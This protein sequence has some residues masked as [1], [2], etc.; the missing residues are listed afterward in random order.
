[1]ANVFVVKTQFKGADRLSPV[2]KRIGINVER[3]GRTATKSFKRATKAASVFGG[4][5]K[6]NLV[7]GAIQRG[8]MAANNAIRGLTEEFV[9][10]DK[11]ITKAIVRLPGGLDRSSDAFQKFG[12]I[13]RR[14]AKRTEFT[15]GE[16]AAAVEQL[17]LAGFDLDTVS[18]TL[19]GV[20]N[21]ATN[22]EADLASATTM[23]VKT[24]GAFSLKG[25]NAADKA[26]ELTRVNNVF[27]KSISS[28]A[29]DMENLFEVIKFGGPAADSAGVKL[30]EFVAVAQI[31]ADASIDS[32]VA[33][34][35]MRTMFTSLA[36]LSPKAT[37]EL[38]KMGVKVKDNRIEFDK[39]EDVIGKIEKATS[40]MG[41]Q[42]RLGALKTIFGK[43]AVNAATKIIAK[44]A[45]GVKRYTKELSGLTDESE[46]MAK[47][48]RTSIEGRLKRLKSALVEVG[49]KF[50]EAFNQNA[51]DSIE[52]LIKTVSKFD[53]KPVVKALKDIISFSKELF[54]TLKPFL[55][56]MPT[57]I[58]MWVAYKAA[59][60]AVTVVQAA[61][62]FVQVATAM[63]TAAAAQGALNLVMA[64]NPIA[65]VTIAIVGLTAALA[66]LIT[67]NDDVVVS[68]ESMFSDIESFASSSIAFILGKLADLT[69]ALA[70]VGKFLGFEGT[71]NIEFASGLRSMQKN[72]EMASKDA[73]RRSREALE[74]RAG[75]GVQRGI[76]GIRGATAGPGVKAPVS[77]FQIAK[78]AKLRSINPL[79]GGFASRLEQRPRAPQ[80]PNRTEVEAKRQTIQATMEFKGDIPRGATVKSKRGPNN[81]PLTT[82][83][84]GANG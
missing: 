68:W 16:A 73:D 64:A 25:G 80:P 83:G 39:F 72:F 7:A 63:K 45:E 10:F 48:I 4:V 60:L 5:L 36:K 67:K 19:P 34:T 8:A 84:L 75:L 40:K 24:M 17:A 12:D 6:G 35:S 44:G 23:A 9:E 26:R 82:E 77:K 42:Q 55:S 32:S 21:L 52:G 38:R 28:A 29:I 79:V 56:F 65:L 69:E 81:I 14:E 41:K 53:V 66:I 15:A 3:T 71:A 78:A 47:T 18:A 58:A 51:G 57:F 61:Q 74:E 22:A 59:M 46:R 31:L 50:I 37:A 11:N 76:A 27:S 20:L 62:F 49:F 1:V 2:L 30:E 54:F 13:A 70:S 33:G 43:T